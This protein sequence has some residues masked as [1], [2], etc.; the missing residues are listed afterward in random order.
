MSNNTDERELSY[1]EW[2]QMYRVSTKWDTDTPER[3]RFMERLELALEAERMGLTQ[4]KKDGE[5]PEVNLE[6]TFKER[7]Q[8]LIISC[9]NF[10]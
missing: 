1:N 4:K 2:A 8:G 9:L 5:L 3:K 10:N 7:F 6:P